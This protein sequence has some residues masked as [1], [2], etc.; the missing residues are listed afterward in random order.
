M[1]N[2]EKARKEAAARFRRA[3]RSEKVVTDPGAIGPQADVVFDFSDLRTPDLGGLSLLLT[4]QQMVSAENRQVWIKE[5][6][7]QTWQILIA[8]GLNGLFLRFP[9]SYGPMD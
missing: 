9:Q 2:Y 5:L 6:P 7:Y 3:T 8:M 4:A 1:N